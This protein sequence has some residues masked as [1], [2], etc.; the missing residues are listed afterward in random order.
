MEVRRQRAKKKKLRHLYLPELLCR[1]GKKASQQANEP[2]KK[3]RTLD[4]SIQRAGFRSK[5]ALAE[6]SQKKKVLVR[7]NSSPRVE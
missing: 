2:K 7:I 1:A 5:K 3:V 6:E 4:L